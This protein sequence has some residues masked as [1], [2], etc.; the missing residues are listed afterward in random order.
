MLLI[1]PARGGSKGIPKKNLRIIDGKPLIFYVI[2]TAKKSKFVDKIVVSTEDEEIAD[3]ASLLGV[4][5]IERPTELAEDHIPLD[6]VIYHVVK[7]MEAQ[8]KAFDLIITLQ[9]TLPLI[10][11]ETIDKAIETIVDGGYDCLI[12]VLDATHL[13][14]IKKDNS[15][16]P[17]FKERK[18]RQYLDSI[19]RECGFFISK[20]EIVTPNS[21]IGGKVTIMIL[22]RSEAIDV[23]T[24]EDLWVVERLLK[25]V[26]IAIRVDGDYDVGLGHIYGMLSLAYRL[27][28]HEIKFFTLKSKKLGVEK[29]KESNF[30][31]V[32]I[33]ENDFIKKLLDYKPHIVINDILDTSKEY[34]L[35]LKEHGFFVVNF[36][37]LGEGMEYADVVFNALYESTI[38]VENQYYGYKY[39]ILR[40]DFYYYPVKQLSSEVKNILL[41]FGGVDQNNLTLKTLRALE[42]IGFDGDVTVVLGLGYRFHDSIENFIK[43][44]SLKV[45]IL[46]NVKSMAKIVYNSDIA[47]TSKGRTVYEIASLA[48]P[49][50]AIAQND[51]E[52]RHLFADLSKGVLSL[53]YANN[54]TENDIAIALKKLID[55]YGLRL[56][57]HQKL[58][59]FDLKQSINNVINIIF[60]KYYGDKKL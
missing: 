20:R 58:K 23:D 21:R 31:L 52:T 40:Q 55:D 18:N 54:I 44:S 19:Y 38:P 13:Y 41:T 35:M 51:R 28:H 49:C 5:V 53:G 10:S 43:K 47:V 29:I 2:E 22:P 32:L 3:A 7:F 26:R 50:I 39:V 16:Y 15:I 11:S 6:P 27:F 12:G 1:V 45:N 9:P 33:D 56:M 46:K 42:D 60:E 25:K 14:W 34:V 17:L 30:P 57:L 36:E 24:Y 8:G 4:E 59:K 48:I 37:D